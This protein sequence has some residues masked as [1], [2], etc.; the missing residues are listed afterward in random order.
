[1]ALPKVSVLTPLYHTNHEHL[2][3]MILS[4]LNQTFGDFEF[5]LLND[6]P[7]D[8]T[9]RCAIES[10]DDPRILYLE[11]EK[12][13][14]ISI[15]RNRLIEEA[16]GEYL[17]VLDH[18]D[19]CLPERLEKQVSYL[20]AHPDVGIVSGFVEAM[21]TGKVNP[22]R[23]PE[24]N[25]DIKRQLLS[26]NC[27]AHSAMMIRKST[28]DATKVRYDPLFF[29]AEDYMLCV[30]LM[31]YTQFY[32][33][34]EVI[35]RYRDHTENVSHKSIE[36]MEDKRRL[37]ASIGRRDFGAFEDRR[38]SNWFFLGFLRIGKV[39]KTHRGKIFLL[40]GFIPLMMCE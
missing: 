15:S 30:E 29:P 24:M 9:L 2:N 33:L 21:S 35:L 14:G 17:A 39:K 3:Q 38:D 25:L 40:F 7:E 20:D 5:L 10:F 26:E 1:M 11:N 22:K 23:Y 28:I 27:L 8:K 16:R 32:N 36:L 13:C 4:V 37:I 34:Q 18:D 19:I 6:S 12:N 31:R